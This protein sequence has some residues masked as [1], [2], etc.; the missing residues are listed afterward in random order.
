SPACSIIAVTYRNR[1]D[2]DAF[3]AALPAAL[4]D[5][6]AR[7][8]VVDNASGDGTREAAERHP[9]VLAIDAGRNVGY[10]G[11]INLGRRPAA[12]G[13]PGLIANP[14]LRFTPRPIAVLLERLATPGAGAAVP[15][16]V[17]PDG[18]AHRSLRREPSLT[19]EVG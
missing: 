15:R 5:A 2:I 14:H 19:R 10:A 8:I 12:P 9:G 18:A 3:L 4:D 16:L 6:T 1:D 13:Q 11:G 17:G 7:V